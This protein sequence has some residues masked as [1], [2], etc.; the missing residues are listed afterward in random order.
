MVLQKS[1]TPNVDAVAVNSD[2]VHV[3]LFFESYLRFK[4]HD[5]INQLIMWPW[6]SHRKPLL[7]AVN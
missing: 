1:H 6:Q 4:I 7:F 5:T 3:Y 2:T